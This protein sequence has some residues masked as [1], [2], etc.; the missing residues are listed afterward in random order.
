[1]HGLVGCLLV[2]TIDVV[3]ASGGGGEHGPS[4]AQLAIANELG[5][6]FHH[7]VSKNNGDVVIHFR[8]SNSTLHDYRYYYHDLRPFGVD[9]QRNEY[10]PR[11]RLLDADNSLR[12]V[13]LH[14]G[15][16]VSCLSFVDQYE[17]VAKP[18]YACYEFTL[19]EKVVG[20]HHGSKSGYL[21]PILI[22]IAFGLHVFI[23]IVHHIKAKN[24]AGKLLDRFINV[25]PKSRLRRMT[26]ANSFKELDHPHIS[27]SVQRRLSRVSV[28][29]DL[30]HHNAGFIGTDELPLYTLPFHNRRLSTMPMTSIPEHDSPIAVDSL[31][32]IRHLMEA[33]PWNRRGQQAR[34]VSIIHE[35]H[36]YP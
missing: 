19:G 24:Y 30:D 1:M 22:A 36:I 25:A 16:Y 10:L 23:A 26:L 27:A 33:A 21:A 17:T 7:S 2:F 29:P 32:S 11:Q 31:A 8:V 6:T 12:I 18:R 4:I 28:D 14:E 9:P 34:S 15:D 35:G 13:G 3:S 5:L 20:S